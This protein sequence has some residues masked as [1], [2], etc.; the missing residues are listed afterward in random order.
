MDVSGVAEGVRVHQVDL[1]PHAHQDVDKAGSA[2]PDVNALQDQVAPRDYAR[3]DHP[4]G[5]LRRVGRDI[6]IGWVERAR[7]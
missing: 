7:L 6:D 4:E 5:S 3:S 1:R 2:P